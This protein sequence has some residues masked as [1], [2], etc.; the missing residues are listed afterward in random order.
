MQKKLLVAAI[1]SLVAG[2]AL[3]AN[4]YKDETTTVDVYGELRPYYHDTNNSDAAKGASDVHEITA[5]GSKLGFNVRHEL[6]DQWYTR[7]NMEWGYDGTRDDG[8]NED[9]LETNYAY[10]AIGSAA[11]GEISM[12]RLD[13]VQDTIGDKHDFSYEVDNGGASNVGDDWMGTDTADNAV[14]YQWTRDG[15]T[16]M[17]QAQGHSKTYEGMQIGQNTALVTKADIRYGAAGG[18]NWQSENGFSVSGTLTTVELNNIEGG[19]ATADQKLTVNSGLVSADYTVGDLTL[20]A[21]YTMVRYEADKKIANETPEADQDGYGLGARYAMGKA[22]VYGGYDYLTTDYKTD[23]VEKEKQT[24]YL[25]GVDY[26]F[27]DMLTLFA[28]YSNSQTDNWAGLADTVADHDGKTQAFA[29]GTRF[30]F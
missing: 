8:D 22:S 3:A 24:V 15:L 9:K 18:V 1:A 30:Y 2:N 29:V 14:G 7:A 26:S 17:L 5:E 19:I 12:G 25:L 6:N 21:T 4:I 16:V 23:G 11:L 13:S 28:E 20:A 27:T 10:V